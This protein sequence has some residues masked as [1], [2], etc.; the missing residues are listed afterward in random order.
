MIW[1]AASPNLDAPRQFRTQAQVRIV[2][3]EGDRQTAASPAATPS[4]DRTGT[5]PGARR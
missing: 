3:N 1:S 5:T 4:C 2:Q